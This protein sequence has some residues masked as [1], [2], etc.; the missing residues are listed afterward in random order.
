VVFEEKLGNFPPAWVLPLLSFLGNCNAE[1]ALNTSFLVCGVYCFFF[2]H[3]F[4]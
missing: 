4:L 2:F 1:E 3:L